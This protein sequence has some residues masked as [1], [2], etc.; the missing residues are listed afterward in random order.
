MPIQPLSDRTRAKGVPPSPEFWIPTSGFSPNM[1][2]EPNLPPQQ[3]KNAKH[4]S[5]RI[6]A[7]TETQLH[8]QRTHGRPKNTERTQFTPTPARPTIQICETNPI[9]ARRTCRRPKNAK[10]TQF[11]PSPPSHRPKNAKRT[12]SLPPSSL[13]P[14][15]MRNTCPAAAQRRRKPNLPHYLQSTIYNIQLFTRLLFSGIGCYVLGV[16]WLFWGVFFCGALL[17]RFLPR[18]WRG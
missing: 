12:Q 14:P 18:R 2:N 9:P 11:A 5:G 1:Q 10:R 3:P 8:P 7:K 6:A 17:L 15:I 4:L 13:V 16:F